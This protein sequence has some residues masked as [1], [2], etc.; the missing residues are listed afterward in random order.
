MMYSEMESK[1]GEVIAGKN[2][3]LELT[4]QNRVVNKELL[5]CKLIIN[6]KD[7]IIYQLEEEL[8]KA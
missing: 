1:Q 7:E 8:I 4:E 5:N 3:L 6:E 2:A